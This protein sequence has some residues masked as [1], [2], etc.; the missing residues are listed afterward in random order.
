[1]GR[2]KK[3]LEQLR[4]SPPVGVSCWPDGDDLTSFTAVII[5]DD[6]TVYAGGMFK[7]EVKV[8]DRYPFLPPKV[9]FLTKVYH[10]NIDTLGRICLDILKM[11]PGGS[12]RP[13]H[14]L[15]TVLTSVRLLLEHPNPDDPLMIDIAAD[16]QLRK[17][18]FDATAREWTAKYAK[19]KDVIP[20]QPET[21]AKKRT[22]E[23]GD[24]SVEE[25]EPAKKKE[26]KG[27]T[28]SDS[29]EDSD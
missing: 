18:M 29:E 1:M 5:G 8:P 20:A 21:S 10:P 4:E 9:R 3:E 6:T 25:S 2:L 15:A 26:R 14:N 11:T 16:Y 28:N 7:L 22:L 24:D 19:D 27:G 17:P 23:A 13:I 12:W